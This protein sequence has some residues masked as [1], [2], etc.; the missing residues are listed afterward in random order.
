MKFSTKTRYA[1][2]TMLEI[3][4]DK[5]GK[6]ILQKDIAFNQNISV[7]YLDHII[8]A[9]KAADL[10]HTIKG[11]KSGYVL[12]RNPSQI[13]MFDIHNAFEEGICVIDCIAL[14]NNCIKD[15]KCNS[16]H[17]WK[18]LNQLVLE[19]FTKYTL[20]DLMDSENKVESL[21]DKST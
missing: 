16:Q 19:Y 6:G 10:I 2:R 8:S 4:S 1:I 7:K 12:S 9:L 14:N 5:S 13:S 21:F 18:G 3:A 17:F 11:K 15:G 20:A